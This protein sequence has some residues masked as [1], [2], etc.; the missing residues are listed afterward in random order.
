MGDSSEK[1]DRLLS[2][3]WRKC[4]CVRNLADFQPTSLKKFGIEINNPASNCETR[5]D[6]SYQTKTLE[7]KLLTHIFSNCLKEGPPLIISDSQSG[8]TK[9][10]S[11]NNNIQGV[12]DLEERTDHISDCG[13]YFL[14]SLTHLML[15]NIPIFSKHQRCEAL[16]RITGG[17]S[18]VLS[19]YDQFIILIRRHRS[20]KGRPIS[21]SFFL[22]A[23]Q[24]ILILV[25]KK[26]L[27]KFNSDCDIDTNVEQVPKIV[28]TI[29]LFSTACALKMSPEVGPV[30]LLPSC[31]GIWC[32]A[33]G[34]L[35]N[36][37]VL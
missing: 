15:Q 12:L 25:K 19:Q 35:L 1:G 28:E 16:G 18:T 4:C 14:T 30:T 34:L 9:G 24:I 3:T 22:I 6:G 17:Q 32:Q 36:T 10:R 27:K 26:S 8:F 20:S 37:C 2:R 13:S 7:C 23:A 33:S 29:E 21:P 11:I 31:G 5:C